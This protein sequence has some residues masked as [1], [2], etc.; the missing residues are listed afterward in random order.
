MLDERSNTCFC[1]VVREFV[2]LLS[3]L[4]SFLYSVCGSKKK[5]ERERYGKKEKSVK[6]ILQGKR[7][8]KKTKEEK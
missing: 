3:F 8:K 2:C 1:L 7:G 5:K 6:E 4:F